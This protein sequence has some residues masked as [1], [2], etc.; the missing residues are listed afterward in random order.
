MSTIE[1]YFQGLGPAVA[2]AFAISLLTAYVW[3][4]MFR[5][6]RLGIDAKLD[7]VKTTLVIFAVACLVFVLIILIVY[8]KKIDWDE[9][10]YGIGLY[11]LMAG[12]MFAGVIKKSYEEK[13]PF[14]DLDAMKFWL[15]LILSPLIYIPILI[16][17]KTD[18]QGLSLIS[19]AFLNGFFWEELIGA[20]KPD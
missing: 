4:P 10:L 18:G 3:I 2:A 9:I 5:K 15:P 12:G 7:K 19:T 8:W 16:L 13:K 1:Y 14:K 6:S 11:L 20:L 17:M